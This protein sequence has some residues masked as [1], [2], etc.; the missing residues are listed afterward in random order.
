PA[1][2]SV[3]WH[4]GSRPW[5]DYPTSPP[6]G[7][8]ISRKVFDTPPSG[9]IADAGFFVEAGVASRM[10]DPHTVDRR[11]MLFALTSSFYAPFAA[12]QQASPRRTAF[13]DA[14]LRQ[15]FPTWSDADRE[16]LRRALGPD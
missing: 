5:W 6:P 2:S 13:T 9:D 4:Q 7:T 10:H 8:S 11:Q 12:G 16:A 3:A 1:P 15:Q 14:F